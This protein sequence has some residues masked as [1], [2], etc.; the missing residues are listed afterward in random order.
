[1]RTDTSYLYTG[2]YSSTYAKEKMIEEYRNEEKQPDKGGIG[3]GHDNIKSHA[4][5]TRTPA[6]K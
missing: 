5:K 1:M 2:Q 4:A 6:H 3:T